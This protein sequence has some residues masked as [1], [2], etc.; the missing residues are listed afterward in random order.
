[1]FLGSYSISR[2]GVFE[3]PILAGALEGS[4]LPP[5]HCGAWLG[6]PQV[7]CSD[8]GWCR[9]ELVCVCSC[10]H[11][12]S[13][14]SPFLVSAV[15]LQVRGGKA[16]ASS[17]SWWALWACELEGELSLH[18]ALANGWGRRCW[19]GAARALLDSHW[20]EGQGGIGP[21]LSMLYIRISPFCYGGGSAAWPCGHL[22]SCPTVLLELELWPLHGGQAAQW[23]GCAHLTHSL[24]ARRG[25]ALVASMPL[26]AGPGCDFWLVLRGHQDCGALSLQLVF[27]GHKLH[28]LKST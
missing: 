14:I 5:Q 7:L 2:L 20:L 13:P 12:E 21:G 17:C 11:A 22:L 16:R 9:G 15:L 24:E 23:W 27:L 19:S 3:L 18:G 26:P 1:M 25:M 10:G 6:A 4:P 28:L 8:Q